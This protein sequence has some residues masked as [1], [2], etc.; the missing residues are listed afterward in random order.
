MYLDLKQL[1]WW[2]NMKAEI[3]TYVSKCLTCTKIKIEHQKPSVLLQQP[4]IPEWKWEQISMDFITNTTRKKTFY[5]AQNTT[6]FDLCYALE[7]D[8]KKVSSLQKF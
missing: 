5:D 6:L 7:S 2:P 3:A 8:I 4:E 1:Y